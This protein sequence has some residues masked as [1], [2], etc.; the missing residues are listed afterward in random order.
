MDLGIAGKI[1]LVSGGTNGI[2][3]SCAEELAR[4]GC[5]V[6]IVARDAKNVTNTVLEFREKH[7]DA[8]GVSA[9]MTKNEGIAKAVTFCKESV[10]HPDIVITNVHGPQHGRWDETDPEDFQ[11]AYND[12][13]MSLVYLFKQVEGHMRD[14]RWGRIVSIGSICVKEPHRKLPLLTANV[15]RVAATALN[16]SLSD[17]LAP[18]GITFNTLATGNFATDRYEEYMKKVSEDRQ[19]PYQ[20]VVDEQAVDIPMKRL[21][22]PDEMASVCAFLCSTRSSYMTGQTIVVDGGVVKTLW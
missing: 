8:T 7:Y 22:R 17:E 4:E 2:G 12:M 13:V 16:K 20:N 18:Y 15:T 1:A 3:K 14:Q 19:K 21:G 9:D 6:V 11:I 10:G 5:R